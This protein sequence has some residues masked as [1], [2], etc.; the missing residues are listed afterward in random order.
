[1]GR[2]E[3]DARG[4]LLRAAIELFAERGYDAT[5]AAQI[6]ERA[7]LT[8]TTLFRQFADKREIVFQGQ[9]SLVE[10]AAVGIGEAP[11]DAGPLGLLA[12]GLRAL[13]SHYGPA[14]RDIGRRLE[15]I[16]ASSPELQERAA[17]K[18]SA[19]TR[20]LREALEGR[21]SDGRL[22]A[23]LA[24]LGARAFY[25]GFDAWILLDGDEPL[26]ESVLAELSEGEAAIRGL[27]T[28]AGSY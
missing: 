14:Q 22:A 12:A 2:W 16:I 27:A 17:Y 20:A 8:K 13:S 1:M 25:D 28:A 19:I 4:R 3:P 11:A 7:G 23:L 15:P 21:I 26:V 10:A 9:D 5:T 18:R 6:A 24:D